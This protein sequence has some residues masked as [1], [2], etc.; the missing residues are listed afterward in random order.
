MEEPPHQNRRRNHEQPERLIAPERAALR[1]AA[2]FFGNL[3]LVRL[4]PAFDH[5]F[6]NNLNVPRHCCFS[7]G[8]NGAQYAL[9]APQAQSA[10]RVVP[11]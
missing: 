6:R 3:L 11:V 4:D 8:R 10:A 1:L 5:W 2:F 9:S 7:I